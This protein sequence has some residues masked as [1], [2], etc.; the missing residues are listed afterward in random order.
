[1][2]LP[3]FANES[4]ERD[5]KFEIRFV[6]QILPPEAARKAQDGA[7]AAPPT[8]APAT[9]PVAAAKEARP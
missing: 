5:W 3:P 6:V 2:P 4:R 1:L 9:Q 7:H 8:T